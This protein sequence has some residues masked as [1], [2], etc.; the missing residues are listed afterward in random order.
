TNV[1]KLYPQT[2][3]IAIPS[4]PQ[5]GYISTLTLVAGSGYT[6]GTYAL[7]VTNP[8]SGTGFAAT[9]TVSSNTLASFNITNHG[10]NYPTSATIGIPAGAGGGT[11]G[12]ITP[13]FT[14]EG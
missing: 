14:G 1:G 3:T 2:A 4:G 8:G 9:V 5:P 12:S 6:N 13:T 10:F 7:T 11:G